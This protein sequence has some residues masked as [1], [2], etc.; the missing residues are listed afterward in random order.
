LGAPTAA[1]LALRFLVE[2]CGLA[3]VAYWGSRVSDSTAVNVVAAIAAPLALATFW[4]VLLAPKSP[5][6]PE[7]PLRTALELLA[8]TV[9]VAALIAAGQPLLGAILALIALVN[10][11]LLGRGQPSAQTHG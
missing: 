9:A 3:A 10:G 8:V 11:L 5:R 4:G 1:N 7:P 2:L 6:R